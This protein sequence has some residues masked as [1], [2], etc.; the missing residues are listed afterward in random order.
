[1]LRALPI[2][3]FVLAAGCESTRGPLSSKGMGRADDPR[4]NTAEQQV[5]G[6]ERYSYVEDTNLTPRTFID[7]PSVA[8]R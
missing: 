6:R 2:V 4:L 5:R 3:L 1:M 8:G 7:R